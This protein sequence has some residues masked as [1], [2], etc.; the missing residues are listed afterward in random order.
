VTKH[1]GA[2]SYQSVI[3]RIVREAREHKLEAGARLPSVRALASRYGVGRRIIE[4][5][6]RR[7]VREGLCYAVN[8]KGVF[9]A[10]EPLPAVAESTMVGTVLAYEGYERE[11]NPFY[12]LLF[13]GAEVEIT[14]RGHD[15]LSLY[16]WSR[17]SARQK[18]LEVERFRDRVAG[19]L[20]LSVCDER[21]CLRLRDAGVPVVA[22]DYETQD[23]GIDCVVIDNSRVM[24]SLCERVLG[25][26]SGPVFLVDQPRA[27]EGDP[28]FPQ[29]RAAFEEALAAAGRPV[30]EEN[31]ISLARAGSGSGE[32]EPLLKAA[33]RAGRRPA[34]V[35]M[36]EFYARELLRRLGAAGPKPGRDFLLAYVGFLAP[37]HPETAEAPAL[38]GAVD[39]R[40]LGREG[41]RLLE[42]RIAG[43]P[44]RALRRTVGGEVVA[45]PGAAP[46]RRQSSR[47]GGRT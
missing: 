47:T 14:G 29:R 10:R 45:W 16:N 7:L 24:G 34:A 15:L 39:Y 36:G 43:G 31:F 26:A 8:R 22:V 13:E 40:R 35:C 28:A 38:I 21:D 25:E 30:S 6:F 11:D 1:E 18:D 19:F 42:E 5:A 9:L 46:E 12:R 23:L 17:K 32:L 4:Q 3:D 44:G 37:Q 20:A 27:S 2:Y 41:V 33:G